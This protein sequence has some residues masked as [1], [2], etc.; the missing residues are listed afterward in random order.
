MNQ[1]IVGLC[2]FIGIFLLG[3]Q[4]GKASNSCSPTRS[5]SV[6][7]VNVQHDGQLRVSRKVAL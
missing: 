1:A 2:I 7:G 4:F 6:M 3:L 5:I